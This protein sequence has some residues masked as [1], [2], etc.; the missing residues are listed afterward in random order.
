[1]RA[2]R[3]SASAVAG[4]LLLAASAC[5]P[6]VGPDAGK[7][8]Q[9]AVNAVA[10]TA[11]DIADTR[12]VAA[13]VMNRDVGDAR[14]RIAGRLTEVLVREGD[15]VRRGQLMAVIS[16]ER[17]R[18]EAQ[19]AASGVEA[20]RSRAELAGADRQRAEI[21]FEKGVYARA[22]LDVARSASDAAEAN[23]RTAKA[24]ADAVRALSEEGRVFAPADGRVTRIPVPE[25]AIVMPGEV[26]VALSTGARVLRVELPEAE[27]GVLKEGE[28]LSVRTGPGLEAVSALVRQVYPA[29]RSG[30]VTADL[31]AQDMPAAFIGARVLVEIPTGRRMAIVIPSGFVAT[32]FGADYVRLARPGG[33]VIEV[34]V[35][36]GGS[37][38]MDDARQGIEILSGLRPGDLIL[39][40]GAGAG[41]T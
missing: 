20:A 11:S 29:V 37:V 15:V 10:V 17:L 13:Q 40:S 12:L 18:L 8:A 5:S 25:G 26:V 27:A 33:R 3:P 23:L 34:P 32:R 1:M 41:P 28:S 24:Q 31:E 30:R 6:A 36:I 7:P 14:A 9:E 4:L 2:S 38:P 19:A 22:R 16:D 39:P 35:Q 21:L